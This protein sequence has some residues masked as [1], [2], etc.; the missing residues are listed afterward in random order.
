MAD[1]LP[2]PLRYEPLTRATV[3]M[4]ARHLGPIQAMVLGLA[5][6]DLSRGTGVL[7][8]DSKCIWTKDGRRITF[9]AGSGAFGASCTREPD[10]R[11]PG[12]L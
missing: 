1:D 12:G 11:A 2:V 4:L 6:A 3:D 5:D 9:W 8:G 7:S 10:P